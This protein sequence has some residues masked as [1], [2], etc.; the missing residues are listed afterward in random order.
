MASL[1]TPGS[2]L[3]GRERQR[4]DPVSIVTIDSP[5]DRT[6]GRGSQSDIGSA[7]GSA[8]DAAPSG[9]PG[10]MRLAR[11]IARPLGDVVGDVAGRVGQF[12]D[13]AIPVDSWL[14]L[15]TAQ[16]PRL[17]RIAREAEVEAIWATANPWSSPVLGLALA[18]AL[19]LPFVADF[20]DPWTLA[21][22]Y[23]AH[24]PVAT[25]AMDALVERRIY[26]EADA[27]VFTARDTAR[28][29]VE[30]FGI[31]ETKVHL[32][33]NSYDPALFVGPLPVIDEGWT[34]PPA[35]PPSAG[36]RL[37]LL[38]LGRFRETSPPTALIRALGRLG[39]RRPDL[40]ADLVVRSVGDLPLEDAR[41]ARDLGVADCFEPFDPVPY[42][43]APERM[44]KADVL[45][46]C[47]AR[48]R[49][50]V[51]PAKLWDYLVGGAPVLSLGANAEVREVVEGCGVGR[52]FTPE[53]V[54]DV[55]AVLEDCLERGAVTALDYAPVR[56]R[57][58]DHGA[59][60]T[61]VRLAQVI[62]GVIRAR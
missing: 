50:E 9:G 43:R 35:G 18:R 32:I 11:S 57:I 47:V 45:L 7:A 30:H 13:A 21:D 4:L 1:A 25:A 60:A 61:T 10:W 48:E 6:V 46:S 41:L 36:V 22:V 49:S 14:P 59:P 3:T 38:F 29:A 52:D 56:E 20:R 16:V 28:L 40:G 17:R 58:L 2:E 23:R 34:P 26:E 44:A 62:D 37:E 55:A 8:P 53:Q 42:E 27:I 31:D 39:E 24:T 51:I 15:L 19:D 5:M 54:D 12:L 33:P